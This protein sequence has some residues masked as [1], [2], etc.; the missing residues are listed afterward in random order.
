MIAA[1]IS[2]PTKRDGKYFFHLAFNFISQ[3]PLPFA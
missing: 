1:G 2:P 3:S